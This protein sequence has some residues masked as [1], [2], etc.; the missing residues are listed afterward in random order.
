[1]SE[2]EFVEFVKLHEAV[3]GSSEFGTLH[4]EPYTQIDFDFTNTFHIIRAFYLNK[5][6]INDLRILV[7]EL[8][9]VLQKK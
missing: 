1:M 4:R 8:D 6:R 3:A 7:D 9:R 2:E 5:F